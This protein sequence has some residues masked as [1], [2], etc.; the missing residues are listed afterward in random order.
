MG[1]NKYGRSWRK[2][3]AEFLSR[4]PCCALCLAQGRVEPATVVDHV[5]PWRSMESP[6]AF[7]DR[8]NWQPLCTSCHSGTK[9]SLEKTGHLRGSDVNGAPLDPRHPWFRE[10][11]E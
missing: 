11:S 8:A 7:W 1:Q 10:E 6:A 9:Q 3:R 5:Q 2:I 4:N